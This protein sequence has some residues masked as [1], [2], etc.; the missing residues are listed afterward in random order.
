MRNLEPPRLKMDIA[1]NR[2]LLILLVWTPLKEA[3]DSKHQS[4]E[5]LRTLGCFSIIKAILSKGTNIVYF[6]LWSKDRAHR[7]SSTPAAFSEECNKVRSIFLNRDYPINL[8]NSSINKFLHNIYNNDA[9]D[10]AGD[11]NSAIILLLPFKDQHSANS[12]IQSK[13]K[14]K[15]WA[16]TLAFTSSPSFSQRRSAE[17]SLLKN[18]SPLLSTL[19]HSVRGL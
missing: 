5:S 17:S 8:I 10:N 11:D 12:A 13:G 9:P 1:V 15:V 2:I 19:R 16:Q 18:R 4:I 14:C 3:K 7:L 6:L